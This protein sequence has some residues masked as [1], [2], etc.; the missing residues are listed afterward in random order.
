MILVGLIFF[1][2]LIGSASGAVAAFNASLSRRNAKLEVVDQYMRFHRVPVPLQRR[3]RAF[4]EYS[5]AAFGTQTSELA[6]VQ[7]LGGLPDR[8][9]AELSLAVNQDLI[10]NVPMFTDLSVA[11]KHAII[12]T[13]RRKMFIPGETVVREGEKAEEV[14]AARPTKRHA[15]ALVCV[16]V[17]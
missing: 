14:R 1:A 8:L 4:L 6:E 7:E 13:V 11:A 2:L 17:L 12:S 3:I 15:T 10:D 5:W 16:C 9:R